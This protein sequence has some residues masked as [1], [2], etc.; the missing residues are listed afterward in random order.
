MCWCHSQSVCCCVP[1]SR[2][3]PVFGPRCRTWQTGERTWS[4]CLDRR[5]LTP[6]WLSLEQGRLRRQQCG[7]FS[8]LREKGWQNRCGMGSSRSKQGEKNT[9]LGWLN[10]GTTYERSWN[11]HLWR[12]LVL[13]CLKTSADFNQQ[14]L[15]SVVRAVCLSLFLE[16]IF[17]PATL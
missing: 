2:P 9:G 10:I 16:K 11:L 5:P 15:V 12:L 1:P 7:A 4:A 3:C 6:A 13:H 8:L 14:S 17:W